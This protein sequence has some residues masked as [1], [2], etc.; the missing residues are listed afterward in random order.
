M[1]KFEA[2]S[3]IETL[4]KS[5]DKI[6]LESAQTLIEFS[7]DIPLSKERQIKTTE[8]KPNKKENVSG[9][10]PEHGN[11]SLESS[12]DSFEVDTKG[13]YIKRIGY[14]RVWKN[15]DDTIIM[16][17]NWKDEFAN[18]A[19]NLESPEHAIRNELEE[20]IYYLEY[21]DDNIEFGYLEKKLLSCFR[22]RLVE[23]F[24]T[25]FYLICFQ[26]NVQTISIRSVFMTIAIPLWKTTD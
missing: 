1:N 6:E 3:A 26:K 21:T 23:I 5:H 10:S 24:K 14:Y 9:L 2:N 18:L 19:K 20:E 12:E 25:L 17:E 15:H 13:R 22:N 11:I 4:I 16:F 7:S 8:Y